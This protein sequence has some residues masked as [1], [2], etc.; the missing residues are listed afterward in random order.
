MNND[1]YP[2]K[3]GWNPSRMLM[4]GPLTDKK[5]EAYRKQGWYTGAF[6][7]ARK[8]MMDRKAAK[9]RAYQERR[10]GNFIVGSDGR[11][12]FSPL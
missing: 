10:D 2:I 1:Y 12:I 3:S 11:L 4:R 7:E 9:R 5:I 8:E 6:R